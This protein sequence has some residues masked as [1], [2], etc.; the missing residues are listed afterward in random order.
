MSSIAIE[1]PKRKR[2]DA[3]L[4]LRDLHAPAATTWPAGWRERDGRR[5]TS[6]KPRGSWPPS[7]SSAP[8]CR[9]ARRSHNPAESVI[10]RPALQRQN[11]CGGR[12]SSQST[13]S[14]RKPET[15]TGK[16]SADLQARLMPEEG[17]EPPTRGLPIPRCLGSTEPKSGAGGRT[18]GLIR[19]TRRYW[20]LVA[21]APCALSRR[22]F[23]P[24]PSSRARRSLR[25]PV[26]PFPRGG[27]RRRASRSGTGPVRGRAAAAR[28]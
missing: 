16:K 1:A 26:W 6:K 18:R 7:D 27:R 11:G 9:S 22:P 14:S 8:S 25:A 13:A 12:S 15:T 19:S 28:R 10:W 17:L 3:A 21:A 4:Q 23:S 24:W 2:P 20:T 5:R